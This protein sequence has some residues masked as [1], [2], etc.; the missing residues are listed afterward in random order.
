MDEYED[1]TDDDLG[2]FAAGVIIS[3]VVVLCGI[4]W[5]YYLFT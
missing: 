3:I 5:L 4:G 2:G 1:F